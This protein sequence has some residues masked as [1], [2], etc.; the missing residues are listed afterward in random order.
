MDSEDIINTNMY[1]ENASFLIE[2]FGIYYFT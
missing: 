1:L 2:Y